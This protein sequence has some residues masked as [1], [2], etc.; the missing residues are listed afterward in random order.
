MNPSTGEATASDLREHT[1]DFGAAATNPASFGEDADGELYI[2]SY[3]GRVYR[4]NT[5]EIARRIAAHSAPPTPRSSALRRHVRPRAA[6]GSQFGDRTEGNEAWPRF[7]REHRGGL[8][9]LNGESWIVAV[10]DHEW[11]LMP[12]TEFLEGILRI[13]RLTH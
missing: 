13:G 2:V 6:A 8:F 11:P 12:L 1:A 10:G 9:V 3:A 5:T 7:A 4:I